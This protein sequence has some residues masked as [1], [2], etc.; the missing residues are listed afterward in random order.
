M[1]FQPTPVSAMELILDEPIRLVE[2][3]IAS[4]DG[5]E[6][7]L[8]ERL[9]MLYTVSRILTTSIHSLVILA[10]STGGGSLGHPK[11]FINL[12]KPGP[13]ACGYVGRSSDMLYC[14][15]TDSSDC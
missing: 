4:C 14:T 3:R 5:G 7:L 11:V 12:D 13:K 8:Q 9:A 6:S 2:Q 1:D 15:S 10:S